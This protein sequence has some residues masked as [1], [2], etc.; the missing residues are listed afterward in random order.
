MEWLKEKL[1]FSISSTE[2]KTEEFTNQEIDPCSGCPQPCETHP[3]YPVYLA[4]KINQSKPL[5]GTVKPYKK[6][7]VLCTG[8]GTSDWEAKI[9]KVE[10]SFAST[11]SSFIKQNDSQINYKVL[12]TASNEDSKGEINPQD[13]K[14]DILVFPKIQ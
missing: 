11:L 2:A 14:M 8:S 13:D 4:K 10:G 7:I 3:T 5:H 12:L 9:E 1:G 6:H